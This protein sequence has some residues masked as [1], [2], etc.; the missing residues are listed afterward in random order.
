[1]RR[2]RPRDARLRRFGVSRFELETRPAAIGRSLSGTVQA[3]LTLTP[4]D[5]FR[6]V[7]SCIRRVTTGSGDDRSTSERILWQE[8]QRVSGR[9]SRTAQGGEIGATDVGRLEQAGPLIALRLGRLRTLDYRSTEGKDFYG[10]IKPAG[11]P[12]MIFDATLDTDDEAA[13]SFSGSVRPSAQAAAK[14]SWP[15][16]TR[17][18]LR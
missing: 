9:P 6:V 2:T 13:S 14:D 11:L 12:A 17:A 18:A 7:L 3:P 5:G 15:S 4:T 1:M 16:W 10:Q 8:E